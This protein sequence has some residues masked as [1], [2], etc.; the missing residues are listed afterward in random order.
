M[1][2]PIHAYYSI[3][4]PNRLYQ[5]RKLTPPNHI[6]LD[7]YTQYL[8]FTRKNLC[9]FLFS[10]TVLTRPLGFRKLRTIH[11]THV[12]TEVAG[13]SSVWGISEYSLILYNVQV[14]IICRQT[15]QI[16]PCPSRSFGLRSPPTVNIR[17][18]RR[19]G[20]TE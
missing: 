4:P 12:L 11:F 17:A 16:R 5:F 9:F 15:R 19:R 3:S 13:K 8:L 14:S 1:P 10:T 6:Q 2:V 20:G 7:H 18:G